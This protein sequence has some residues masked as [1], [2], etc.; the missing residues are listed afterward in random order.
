M[1]LLHWFA[2]S[3]QIAASGICSVNKIPGQGFCGWQ[4]HCECAFIAC[5]SY[6][7]NSSVC[8]SCS[9]CMLSRSFLVCVLP[10]LPLGDTLI[11]F[12]NIGE[13][14][15]SLALGSFVFDC[16]LHLLGPL[17]S[18]VPDLLRFFGTWQRPLLALLILLHCSHSCRLHCNLR[19]AAVQKPTSQMYSRS[20][21]LYSASQTLYNG[22]QHHLEDPT[23]H[24]ARETACVARFAYPL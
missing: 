4:M 20:Q 8:V 11:L 16:C 21:T 6:T 22:L 9:C 14:L 18:A 12:H 1:L 2:L 19:P 13:L 3:S 23:M 10:M 24:K 7:T 17:L 15:E 5:I